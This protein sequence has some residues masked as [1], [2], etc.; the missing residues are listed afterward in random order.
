MKI[1]T[2]KI[3][4]LKLLFVLLQRV[5][6]KQTP[7]GP[8]VPGAPISRQKPPSLPGLYRYY[9]A[10]GKMAYLGASNNLARGHREHTNS[11]RFHTCRFVF[12]VARVGITAGMLY[13][14][15]IK[16]IKRHQPLL[17]GNCG[18]GGRRWIAT[19]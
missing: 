17:N 8:F 2:M 5:F 6:F 1:F 16:K 15:E 14:H 9:D 4:L 10:N 7:A 13:A 11:G 19:Q 3:D 18:G 12:Q